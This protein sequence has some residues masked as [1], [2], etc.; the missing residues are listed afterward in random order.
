MFDS[1]PVY[2]SL[3]VS[4]LPH[5]TT[6]CGNQKCLQTLPDILCGS[7]GGVG[8]IP[9]MGCYTVTRNGCAGLE[10]MNRKTF[11]TPARHANRIHLISA[12]SH[13]CCCS[14]TQLCLTFCDPP[15]LQ[16]ARPPCPSPSPRV[17]P[18]SC[19]LMPS[20]HLILCHFHSLLPSILPRIRVFS[21]ELALCAR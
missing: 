14:V 19:P 13:C 6:H 20:N 9:I 7:E 4:R 16:H 12:T 10:P 2:Y 1:I 21:T 18:S 8:Y 3:D 17:C 11:T 15:G 5:L